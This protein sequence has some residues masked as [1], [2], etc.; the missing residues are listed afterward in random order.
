MSLEL[1]ESPVCGLVLPTIVDPLVAGL[2]LGGLAYVEL[3][4]VHDEGLQDVVWNM[5]I[6]LASDAEF[7]ELLLDS[8]NAQPG[9]GVTWYYRLAEDGPLH[10]FPRRGLETLWDLTSETDPPVA[11]WALLFASGLPAT[12]YARSRQQAA[13][14]GDWTDH[15]L[16]ATVA[17]G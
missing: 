11:A 17:L 5:E 14:W 7:T 16:V 2:S 3:P 6:Q 12:V 1:V 9:A 10:P 15:G 8:T 13:D 4:L